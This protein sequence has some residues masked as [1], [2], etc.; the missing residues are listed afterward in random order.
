MNARID[1]LVGDWRL[2]AGCAR[3]QFQFWGWSVTSFWSL[4]P[5][6]VFALHIALID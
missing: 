2:A 6:D 4:K 3:Q 1:Q 5:S